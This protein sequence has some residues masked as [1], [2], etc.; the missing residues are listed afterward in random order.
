MQRGFKGNDKEKSTQEN[1]WK[2]WEE[3]QETVIFELKQ[4]SASLVPGQQ[5]RHSTPEGCS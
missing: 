4:L 3:R 5:G 1:L 2:I